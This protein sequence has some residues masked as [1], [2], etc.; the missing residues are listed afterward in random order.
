MIQIVSVVNNVSLYE[1][2]IKSNGLMNR[3]V[4]H[5]YDNT[6]ENIG[7]AKRYNEF[8]SKQLPDDAW[9]IFC[10]QDFYFEEDVA[11]RLSSLDPGFL[12]G[13]IG[14]GPSRQ[15][16]AVFADTI[17]A[18]R[19]RLSTCRIE[20]LIPDFRGALTSLA[21]VLKAQPDVLN[22]NIETVPSLYDRVRPQAD[23]DRSLRLL[24][25]AKERGFVTKSGM[26]LG[27]GEGIGEVR[28]VLRELRSTGCDLLTIGQYLRPHHR[29]L[30]VEAYYHPDEFK[31]LRTEALG[32]GF[33][34]VSAGPLVRSSYRA[35]HCL[36]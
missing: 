24:A 18:I 9:I 28:S 34:G 12:Y 6:H 27:L 33:R 30:P 32:M 15:F 36:L 10:H 1:S 29:A 14:A 8:L 3:H 13:P 16:I 17:R 31:A 7:V 35:E 25:A 2:T 22:H 23:Y 26:M 20:A 11:S 21:L 19:R 4:L 5:V